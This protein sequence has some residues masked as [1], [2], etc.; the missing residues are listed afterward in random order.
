[1]SKI[2]SK[3][4]LERERF[5]LK[6]PQAKDLAGDLDWIHL[7]GLS[8]NESEY[9]PVAITGKGPKVLLLHGFDSNFLE[10]RKLVP[11]L[12]NNY[13]LIIPDLF[14]FGFC[15]RSN[16][17]NYDIESIITHLRKTIDTLSNKNSFG[18]IGASMG[19]AIA[20]EIARHYPDKIT[21]LLL[22]SPAGLVGSKTPVPSPLNKLGV[23]LLSLEII[24]SNLCKQ[25]FA[26][27][28]KNVGESEI[29]ISL[30]NTLIPGWG[31]SLACFAKSGGVAN[32]G[33]PLPQTPLKVI[34]GEDDRILN[35]SQKRESK[36]LLG[37]CSEELKECGHLP[38]LERP[39]IIAKRWL[40]KNY[41]NG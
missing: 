21:R 4:I 33:L 10:F 9:F 29:Q 15:P 26:N 13:Q 27:A 2:S 5:H 28:V 35:Q 8:N 40:S 7:D 17:Y 12:K 16:R 19:G 39:E 1:M 24:R 25:A 23:W 30:L 20:M 36:H 3:E 14:G 41:F 18:I 11:L 31:E 32:L 6:D 38:H 34:W 37:D 22:L